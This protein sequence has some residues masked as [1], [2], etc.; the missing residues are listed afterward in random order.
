MTDD[1]YMCVNVCT[2]TY[3]LILSTTWLRSCNTLVAKSTPNTQCVVSK[4]HFP[5][6]G[7]LLGEMSTFRAETENTRQAWKILLNK[8]VKCSENDGDMSEG[9]QREFE[10]SQ[11]V[12]YEAV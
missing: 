12:K 5:L 9:H 11:I 1:R 8:K 3:F 10:G 2:H 6:N 4:G 7:E